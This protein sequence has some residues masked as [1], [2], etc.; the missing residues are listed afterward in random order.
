MRI[1]TPFDTTNAALAATV[2]G[3]T[4]SGMTLQDWAAALAILYSILLIVDKAT[5]LYGR[6]KGRG[7]TDGSE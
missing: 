4:F 2:I 7:I 3:A 1:A 6:W 5:V